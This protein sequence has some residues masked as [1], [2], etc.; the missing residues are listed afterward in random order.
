MR[1][2]RP[3]VSFACLLLIASVAV[4]D[5]PATRLGDG[6]A[7]TRPAKHV[8]VLAVG[9][10]FSG[11]ATR[12]LKEIVAASGN[13]LTLGHAS[14]G[15]C[16][17]QRH[18]R[19]VE[20]FEANPDDPQGRPYNKYRGERGEKM[21]LRE[22]LVAEPWDYIT[23]QQVSIQ[24]FKPE[25]FQPEAGKLH[26][27]V[28]QYAPGGEV[29]LHQTW[30]Y[31]ADDP[32][33]KDG[34]TQ[35]Q[36]YDGIRRSYATLAGEL[37]ARIIPVGDAFQNA[38]RHPAWQFTW[39]DPD[40]DYANPTHPELPDQS[41]S[42]CVGYRWVSVDGKPTLR[43][44]GHHANAAGQYLGAAVWF[45][46]LYGQSVVGNAFVPPELTAEDVALLQR[47]AHE[48]VRNPTVRP[49]TGPS[50]PRSAPAAAN[51]PAAQPASSVP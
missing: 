7:A 43:M 16:S 30:A 1:L 19:H 46:F 39:P 47:V 15:G 36:M 50:S 27:Y 33:F 34:F 45:E 14:I 44:D 23:L 32:L 9:N 48:T 2:S 22:A 10:S 51:A 29:V 6:P 17:L 49:A 21:S 8:R 20:A 12:F 37:G 24:S 3:F 28:R 41:H 26:A 18:W 5:G 25:T 31:R 4:A 13:E 42:L 11:N 38:R 35:E 40:Y